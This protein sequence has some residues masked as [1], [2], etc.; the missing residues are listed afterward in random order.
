[1][2]LTKQLIMLFTIHYPEI[3]T[4]IGSEER[5]LKFLSES[6]LYKDIFLFNCI[7]K[8]EK[9]LELLRL[10]AWQI[11]SEVNYNEL[12]KTLKIDNQTIESYVNMLEQAFVIYKLNAFNTNQRKELKKSKKIYFN[13]LGI[14]NALINDFRPIEIRNDSGAIFENFVINEFRKQNE[15]QQVYANLYFWRT[16]NQ[17]EIDLVI[18]KNGMLHAFEIKWNPNKKAVL[19]KSFSN[20]YPNHTFD[21]VNNT[22]FFE[23]VSSDFLIK[24][25]NNR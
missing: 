18:E 8:P 9:I 13:D 5:L 23:F 21:V 22:N 10:L 24:K 7:K 2:S 1:M 12:S 16:T 17:K 4:G 20:I 15:Y 14:R 6:Y 3:V 19:T 11:G 25:L